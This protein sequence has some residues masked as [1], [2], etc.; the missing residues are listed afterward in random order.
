[1]SA[2][3]VYETKRAY[4][5]AVST[6]PNKIMFVK[7]TRTAIAGTNKVAFVPL[8]TKPRFFG[9]PY[10]ADRGMTFGTVPLGDS[11]EHGHFAG[12]YE[13]GVIYQKEVVFF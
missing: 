12:E 9:M 2:K 7:S 13:S 6:A 1:M 11:G 10:R 5:F 3:Y 4:H 8:W